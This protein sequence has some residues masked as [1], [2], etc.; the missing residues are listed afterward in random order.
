MRSTTGRDGIG[1]LWQASDLSRRLISR[2]PDR[3]RYGIS[4]LCAAFC[5]WPL[6]RGARALERAGVMP[7]HWPLKNYR[8]VSFYVMRTDAL[9]RFGTKLERRFTR[10]QIRT[11]LESSGFESIRFS[12]SPPY[13]CVAGVKSTDSRGGR[14]T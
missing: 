7:E 14:S 9:D 13:W 5:Y 6:A 4:Q 8:D 11:M 2:L 10:E 1:V 3:T 12:Q